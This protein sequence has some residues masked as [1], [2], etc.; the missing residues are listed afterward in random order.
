MFGSQPQAQPRLCVTI[1]STIGRT[2]W[3]KT[4]VVRPSA[5]HA[6]ELRHYHRWI[7]RGCTSPSQFA[8]FPADAVHPLS[9]WSRAKIGSSSF[10]AVAL[11][12]RVSKKVELLFRQRADPRLR[13]VHRQP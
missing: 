1:H 10:G 12:K 9:R 6:V 3:S 11:T 7:Q 4:E 13:V 5:H 2:D 8:Y